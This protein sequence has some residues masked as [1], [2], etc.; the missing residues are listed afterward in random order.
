MQVT[1]ND[2]VLDPRFTDITPV[3]FNAGGVEADQ[4][5]ILIVKM[6]KNQVGGSCCIQG[7]A[8]GQ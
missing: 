2:F 3:G 8:W 7:I 1:S 6:R 4:K 5:G